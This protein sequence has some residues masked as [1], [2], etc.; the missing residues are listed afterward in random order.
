MKAHGSDRLLD[1]IIIGTGPA[2]LSALHAAKMKGLDAAGIDKGPVASGLASHPTYMRWFSTADKL[3][4][5]G[6]PL[7]SGEKNPTRREYLTYCRNFA[8]YFGLSVITYRKVTAIRSSGGVFELDATDPFGRAQ[9]WRARNVIAA[10]GF[11][12]SPRQLDVPGEDLPKVT[13]RYT[14]AHG[15]AGHEVLVIGGGS[16]AAEV[17]L[18]LYR[19][20]ASVTVAM[21][22]RKFQTKYWIEPDI[23][24]RISEG[25]IV[26][27]R[28]T[29]VREIRPDDA[30]LEGKGKQFAVPNDFVLAMIGYEPDTGLLEAAGAEVD[31]STGKPVLT[32]E[33]ES[34]VPGLYVA[35][36]LCAGYEANVVFVENGREHGP[37]IVADIMAKKA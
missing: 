33:Y 37:R 16:S 35:G 18:E 23:E 20:E 12:D 34:T 15:Y 21:L 8:R 32:D 11:Y 28:E 29:R 17:A 24:N 14:E 13:H 9:T 26:C 2:G 19:A 10:T 5:G 1:L 4:L 31:K 30:V 6:F 7:L 3:E 27:Y 22:E 36:T 25:S